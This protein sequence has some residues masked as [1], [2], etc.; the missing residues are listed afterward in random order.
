MTVYIWQAPVVPVDDISAKSNADIF[1]AGSIE[2][3]KAN[4][5]QAEVEKRIIE[6]FHNHGDTV[7]VYNPRRDD[8]DSSWEQTPAFRTKFNEQVIWELAYL[9]SAQIQIFNFEADTISPITL[10]EFGLE[11][12]SDAIKLVVC[13]KEFH[14]YGNV[15]ITGEYLGKNVRFYESR[16]ERFYEDLMLSIQRTISEEGLRK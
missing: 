15:K 1:L 3:G 9:S 11:V 8:W 6:K 7:H 2:M 5:W 4:N 12:A 13:P 10:M 14:R 16:D